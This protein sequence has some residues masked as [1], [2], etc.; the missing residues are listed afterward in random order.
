MKS[1]V[2]LAASFLIQ[3]S[4][5]GYITAP[6]YFTRPSGSFA[7][8]YH[9][10]RPLFSDTQDDEDSAPSS[11]DNGV[12]NDP[13][14]R[15]LIIENPQLLD[16]LLPESEANIDYDSNTWISSDADQ[17]VVDAIFAR[18][19]DKNLNRLGEDW[20]AFNNL[21]T[22]SSNEAVNTTY[23]DEAMPNPEDD[24]EEA[25]L[26][27]LASISAEEINFMSKEA[28]RADKV[29]QMQELGFGAE[30]IKNTLGVATD[31]ELER[32]LD[33]EVFEAFKEE[34]AKSGFGML[35]QDDID[36][37][38]VESHTTVDW[39][40][41]LDEPVRSQMVYVDEHTCIG[42][43]NCAMIAQSTFFME[44]EHGRAR[45]FQQWGDDDETIQIAIATCPVDCI[46][47]VPYDELKA[48]E[49]ERRDQNIN[50]KARLVNQGEY[51]AS[52]GNTAKYGGSKKFT[53][54]QTISGNMGARCNNCPSRGCANCPMYGVGKNP[55][56]KKKEKQRKERMQKAAIKRRRESEEKRAEL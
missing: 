9:R 37:E 21:D 43:T 3:R 46:H 15:D 22:S 54:A 36:M 10:S 12:P 18:K 30:S 48:L 19:W 33:N 50:F 47:Y 27:T 35:V 40:D 4:C 23:A 28:E 24:G 45:V 44:A 41:D 32:D 52:A 25:W 20:S 51:Q 7:K 5:N 56:F 39:D 2:A 14:I 6:T 42:C 29:R 17:E 26:D 8:Q 13:T 31:D 16:M 49:I 1:S 38:T 34:T 53:E 55:E 11:D